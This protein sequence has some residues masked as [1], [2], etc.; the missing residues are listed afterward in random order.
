MIK[1]IIQVTAGNIKCLLKDECDSTDDLRFMISELDRI[2]LKLL[3]VLEENQDD[4]EITQ[5]KK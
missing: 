2:K 1:L 4:F 3:D 5:E